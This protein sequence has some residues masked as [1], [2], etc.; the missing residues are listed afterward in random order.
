MDKRGLHCPCGAPL[1]SRMVAESYPIEGMPFA[2][3]VDHTDRA[4]LERAIEGDLIKLLAV[5]GRE[6]ILVRLHA[7]G[8]FFDEEYVDFWANMLAKY[9]RLAVYGYT[10]RLPH[11]QIGAEIDRLRD[12]YGMRFA[13]RYSDGGTDAG[14]ATVSIK[15]HDEAPVDAI[16]CPEQTGK[17]AACATCGLCWHSQRRIAFVEH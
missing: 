1:N 9:D 6:G 15:S 8:D 13:I 5:R 11:T 17:T 7:L 14:P 4:E 3:R 12:L 2:K 10:A 16:V